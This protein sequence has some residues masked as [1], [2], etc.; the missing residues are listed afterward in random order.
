MHIGIVSGEA[1]GDILGASLIR[2]FKEHIPSCQF[3]GIGGA[4]MLAEGFES[5]FPQDRLAVMGL[6]EPLKRLPELLGIRQSLYHHFTQKN[7]DLVIGIDSPDF[8][9]ALEKKLRLQ[10]TDFSP[11]STDW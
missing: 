11:S 9:L 4:L 6:I 1:S 5:L 2:A 3:S 10:W 7:V 8:N